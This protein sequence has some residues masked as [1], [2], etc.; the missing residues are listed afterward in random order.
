MTQLSERIIVVRNPATSHA[1]EVQRCV[2][3]RLHDDGL[4]KSQVKEFWT[5]SP[6][7]QITIESLSEVIQPGDQILVAAGDG[8]GNAVGNAFLQADND[9]ARVGFLRYGNNN[10]LAASFT[11][12]R[13]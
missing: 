3:D 5:P 8:T 6:N 7:N 11:S 1:D 9:G 12:R 10:D 13:T 2:I 4:T